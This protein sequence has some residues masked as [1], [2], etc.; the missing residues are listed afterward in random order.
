MKCLRPPI[1]ELITLRGDYHILEISKILKVSRCTVCNWLKYYGISRNN[2]NVSDDEIL[3]GYQID[4]IN[5]SLLGDA[6]IAK[7]KYNC[8]F[9][10]VQ[11]KESLQYLQHTYNLLQPFSCSIIKNFTGKIKNSDGVIWVDKSERVLQYKFYTVCHPIFNNLREKWYPDGFKKVP[12]DIVINP[13]MILFWYLD[14]GSHNPNRK[15]I[16]IY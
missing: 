2:K 1:D 13:V 3:S 9:S 6:Y 12:R 10:K 4:V 5:G 7:N 14:D 8:R 16:S 15:E 11:C